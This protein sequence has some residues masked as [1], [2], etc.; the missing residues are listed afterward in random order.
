MKVEFLEARILN[1]SVSYSS[2][3][4]FLFEADP[5]PYHE[6]NLKRSNR[7]PLPEL[8]IEARG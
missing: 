1:I 8:E 7:Q 5:S 6:L 4:E 3:S 2:G